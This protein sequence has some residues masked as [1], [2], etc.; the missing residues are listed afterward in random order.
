ML[1]HRSFNKR[2][3]FIAIGAGVIAALLVGSARPARAVQARLT[4]SAQLTADLTCN[5]MGHASAVTNDGHVLTTRGVSSTSKLYGDTIAWSPATADWGS[6]IIQD[7]QGITLNGQDWA[8]AATDHAVWVANAGTATPGTVT[9]S[10]VAWGTAAAFDSSGGTIDAIEIEADRW[11]SNPVVLYRVANANHTTF[12]LKFTYFVG[13][14]TSN[15]TGWVSTT[16]AA[17]SNPD[18][19]GQIVSVQRAAGPSFATVVYRTSANKITVVDIFFSSST[20]F[21]TSPEFTY[22]PAAGA[23]VTYPEAV[24]D[25]SGNLFVAFDEAFPTEDP[26][27]VFLSAPNDRSHTYT[28]STLTSALSGAQPRYKLCADAL[29]PDAALGSVGNDVIV[30]YTEDL[31]S[32]TTVGYK[33]LYDGA[34][35]AER[36]MLTDNAISDRLI[37][38]D[39]AYG[40]QIPIEY[41]AYESGYKAAFASLHLPPTFVSAT[42]DR[43]AI[44]GSAGTV[45]TLTSTFNEPVSTTGSVTDA[46]GTPVASMSCISLSGDLPTKACS[47]NG[48]QSSGAVAP[49]GHYTLTMTATNNT[50]NN[51]SFSRSVSK[52]LD[53]D[54][55]PP[56][57]SL[58]IPS[59]DGWVSATTVPVSWSGSDPAHVG[60]SDLAAVLAS[61]DSNLANATP[62]VTLSCAPG[63][64]SRSG[65]STWTIPPGDGPKTV[66][67]W[68]QDKA[69]NVTLA[70]PSVTLDTVLPSGDLTLT[71]LTNGFTNNAEVTFDLTQADGGTFASGPA[72][73][74]YSC[75]GVPSGAFTAVPSPSTGSCTV[76]AG[77]GSK[78]VRYQ[79]QDLAG[80]ISGIVT[81]TLTLD[82]SG[83]TVTGFAASQPFFSPNADG[84]KDTTTLTASLSDEWTPLT[85]TASI[86][87]SSNHPVWT[88]QGTGASVSVTWDGMREDGSRVTE[89]TY[90]ATVTAFDGGMNRRESSSIPIVLDLTPPGLID[91]ALTPLDHSNVASSSVPLAARIADASSEIDA[92]SVAF[93]LSDETDASGWSTVSGVSLDAG[94]GWAKTAPVSLTPGHTYRS[95]VSVTDTAGNTGTF[96][97]DPVWFGGGFLAI[98][99]DPHAS[100]ADIAPVVC[101]LS[102][103]DVLALARTATCPSPILRV[104][105][106][107]IQL[108]GS[109]HSNNVG[110]VLQD[111]PLSTAVLEFQVASGV[112]LDQPAYPA[113]SSVTT[114]QRYAA[115][116]SFT[117]AETVAV[118]AIS[119]RLETLTVSVP[120]AW[121]NATLKMN[122]VP[123]S[124]RGA[125]GYIAGTDACADP[126]TSDADPLPCVPDPLADSFVV[127]VSTAA[128]DTAAV[129]SSLAE[130]YGGAIAQLYPGSTQYRLHAPLDSA[131]QIQEDSRV[132][133]VVRDTRRSA[134]LVSD[135]AHV[136]FAPARDE[137]TDDGTTYHPSI[138]DGATSFP[139]TG[140]LLTG[141]IAR[142]PSQGFQVAWPDGPSL[143]VMPSGV[144]PGR[145]DVAVRMSDDAVLFPATHQDT[146][147]IL[148]AGLYGIETF[149][150]LGS[151]AAPEDF[152]WQVADSGY[153][154]NP[155]GDG[156]EIDD[157]S[158]AI[159][160][161]VDGIHA[162]DAAGRAV[163]VTATAS[164]N[165]LAVHVAHSSDAFIYPV[166][167]DP[168]FDR[169]Q[170][171]YSKQGGGSVKL[172]VRGWNLKDCIEQGGACYSTA[173][174]FKPECTAQSKVVREISYSATKGRNGDSLEG[175]GNPAD[176]PD[177]VNWEVG[178]NKSDESGDCPEAPPAQ[179]AWRADVVDS[180]WGIIEVKRWGTRTS[181]QVNQQLD[182]YI[183][184]ANALGVYWLKDKFLNDKSWA[185]VYEGS[186][187]EQDL[188]DG[189]P[190]LWYA[191]ANPGEDGI[192]WFSDDPPQDVKDRARPETRNQYSTSWWRKTAE[193]IVT[194]VDICRRGVSI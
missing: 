171:N 7:N 162:R 104:D 180:N 66:W 46:S 57:A 19:A 78:S 103:P 172:W 144:S 93:S 60:F 147:T 167:L 150:M 151:P 190:R 1:S 149:E 80:N 134:G 5:G 68:L 110:F 194:L 118:P 38:G 100:A 47:W 142:D 97:Q 77:D 131:R 53:V 33:V 87:D 140:S 148:R 73:I 122:P 76:P 184:N 170:R 185:I 125:P 112:T 9:G 54:L 124:L 108:S 143:S 166:V 52:A 105:E 159:V 156:F 114:A 98:S 188:I 23:S 179:S 50:I 161:T 146:D 55:T 128:P 191:W 90:N 102:E 139:I 157:A 64:G 30:A 164:G 20:G 189:K 158:G 45:A 71:N 28:T 69:G 62:I 42:L 59:S 155:S 31:P 115:A 41:Q 181:A 67:L 70:M 186:T 153:V 17:S 63:C 34:W 99:A 120:A 154:I 82:T 16:L 29:S 85:W 14:S 130:T 177:A 37:L 48:L 136:A 141:Q 127:S 174:N 51:A 178:R 21:T 192:V 133:V 8:V 15:P 193:V 35:S 95:K 84:V 24:A 107:T 165:T 44:S 12:S 126:T 109:R 94:T 27:L 187:K 40:S 61:N 123:G 173:D 74:R 121:T 116:D 169:H 160:A 75:T 22:T 168:S 182:G 32:G 101:T 92:A 183:A 72:G 65:S 81:K 119:H 91:S 129:A 111:V 39:N 10:G 13:I 175:R 83:P 3:S 26:R 49:E 132:Q 96:S 163:P 18:I 2:A 152:T 117:A 79:V 138:S 145:P 56:E 113:N 88:A 135:L 89:G 6:A 36:T 25:K 137:T 11:H 86:A 43:T 176:P 106:T 58:S 4:V